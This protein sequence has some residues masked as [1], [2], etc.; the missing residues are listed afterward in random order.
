MEELSVEDL[1]EAARIVRENFGEPKDVWHPDYGWILR[2]GKP[3][4]E[5]VKWY[6][7]NSEDLK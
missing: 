1:E 6:K 3:T 5:G 7:D 2:D 4:E